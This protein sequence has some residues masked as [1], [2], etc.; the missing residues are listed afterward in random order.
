MAKQTLR[1]AIEAEIAFMHE[2]H[3]AALACEGVAK[4]LEEILGRFPGAPMTNQTLREAIEEFHAH[5]EHDG[6]EVAADELAAVLARFPKPSG[7][8]VRA[9]FAVA[10]AYALNDGRPMFHVCGSD[11]DDD[12]GMSD[13]A[14]DAF[15][16]R[17]PVQVSFVEVDAPLPATPCALEAEVLP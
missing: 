11:Q 15:A 6:W 1:E 9:R 14:R 17:M 5:L 12:A 3:G 2:N 4:R 16:S 13:G 10:T 7:P 8:T